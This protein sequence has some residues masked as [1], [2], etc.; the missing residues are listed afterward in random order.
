MIARPPVERPILWPHAAPGEHWHPDVQTIFSY[1]RQRHPA[2]GLPGRQH[3][4][5][6][7]V[8]RLLPG[9]W[10]L[11]VQREPFRL[12]YRL[13]GTRITESIG[14]EV[15]GLWMD[16]AHPDAPS[17]PGYFDRY[18][19]VVETAQPS[20]RKGR[21]QLYI[22]EDYSHLENIL[23]PLARDGTTVDMLFVLTAIHEAPA[24]ARPA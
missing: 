23:L 10:L 13:V 17:V 8:V 14:R 3:I 6:L 15:T 20:W 9:V 7:D 4:D 21:P 19:A 11:D 16:E 24:L 12:R 5:P 22:H 18:R 2:N 1:W